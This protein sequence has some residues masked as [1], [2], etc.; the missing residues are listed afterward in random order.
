[1]NDKRLYA[2]RRLVKK[3]GKAGLEE[4]VLSFIEEN[5]SDILKAYISKFKVAI[6]GEEVDLDE[7]KFGEEVILRER[8]GVLIFDFKNGEILKKV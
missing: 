5:L 7:L 8:G 4:E 6:N 2:Y 1:M 3:L